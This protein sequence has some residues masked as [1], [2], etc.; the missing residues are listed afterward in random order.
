MKI[1]L[2]LLIGVLLMACH[3]DKNDPKPDPIPRYDL[4]I[5]WNDNPHDT[6]DRKSP[7]RVKIRIDGDNSPNGSELCPTQWIRLRVKY[8]P[9][10]SD[11][12]PEIIR[13][14]DIGLLRTVSEIPYTSSALPALTKIGYYRFYVWDSD[15]NLTQR[16]I[17]VW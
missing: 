7:Y 13:D 9:N 2:L 15:S 6:L 17:K 12:D 10:L 16:T 8:S 5:I 4:R 3:H 11:T 14:S 1:R